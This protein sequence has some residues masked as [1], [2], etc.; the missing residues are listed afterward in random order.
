LGEEPPRLLDPVV[1]RGSAGPFSFIETVA[2]AD[3][4][5]AA[6]YADT[7]GQLTS[8]RAA[9]F[10]GDGTPVRSPVPLDSASGSLTSL[11]VTAAGNET[12]AAA[13]V[14]AGRIGFATISRAG[15]GAV[16]FVQPSGLSPSDCKVAADGAFFVIAC[17]MTD[18]SSSSAAPETYLYELDGLGAVSVGPLLMTADDGVIS[19]ARAVAC[20]GGG[21]VWFAFMEPDPVRFGIYALLLSSLGPSETVPRAPVALGNVTS[22]APPVNLRGLSEPGGGVLAGFARQSPVTNNSEVVVEAFAPAVLAPTS[23]ITLTSAVGEPTAFSISPVASASPPQYLIEWMERRPADQPAVGPN[24][25]RPVIALAD[26]RLS[27]LVPPTSLSLLIPEPVS[28]EAASGELVSS[29]GTLQIYRWAFASPPTAGPEATGNTAVPVV[30][31]VFAIGALIPLA[32][33][34][35]RIRWGLIAL[36]LPFYARLRGEKIMLDNMRRGAIV[37]LI[38]DNPGIRFRQLSRRT[39]IA[40]GA[41]EHHL[42]VLQFHGFVSKESVGREVR[43]YLEGKNPIAEEPFAELRER[44]LSEIRAHPGVAHSMLAKSMGVKWATLLYHVEA[45]HGDGQVRYRTR[46]GRRRYWLQEPAEN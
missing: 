7:T 30:V 16:T 3:G 33:V 11:S 1:L 28:F 13:W 42:R 41:L 44:I 31:V 5:I 36:F 23:R 40:Q 6:T 39:G 17:T 18:T 21:N 8:L 22:N 24:L 12:A 37:Q 15:V 34:E 14:G 38:K 19:T 26:E 4:S 27:L 32:L 35:E 45:L 20:D 43:F 2:F 9:V 10:L 46:R 25:L 29:D